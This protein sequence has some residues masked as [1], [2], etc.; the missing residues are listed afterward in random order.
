MI[1]PKLLRM[2]AALSS[3]LYLSTAGLAAADTYSDALKS[4]LTADTNSLSELSKAQ[5]K[6]IASFYKQRNYRPI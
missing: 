4:R 3:F 1:S 5:R 6:H 2:A